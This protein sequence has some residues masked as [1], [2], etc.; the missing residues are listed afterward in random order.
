MNFSFL[1]SEYNISCDLSKSVKILLK[2]FI[3]SLKN[4]KYFFLS[5]V[6]SSFLIIKPFFIIIDCGE[7]FGD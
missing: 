2:Q 7:I 4:L 6:F 3:R 1:L 5:K